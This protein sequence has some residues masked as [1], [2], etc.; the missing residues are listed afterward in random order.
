ML[1]VFCYLFLILA[2][3]R[4]KKKYKCHCLAKVCHLLSR[5]TPLT[6]KFVLLSSKSIFVGHCLSELQCSVVI[7][8]CDA[9]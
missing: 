8:A 9:R 2:F 7:T 1:I 5:L 3:L 4:E 6:L